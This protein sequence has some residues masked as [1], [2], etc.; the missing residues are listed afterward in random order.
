MSASTSAAS[1]KRTAG[2]SPGFARNLHY[3]PVVI[4]ATVAGM[5]VVGF[6]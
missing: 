3:T 2:E 5:P 1:T 6:S 4:G